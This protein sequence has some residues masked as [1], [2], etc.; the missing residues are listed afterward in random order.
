[1]PLTGQT[2]TQRHYVQFSTCLLICCTPYLHMATSE[3][4]YRP[5]E[6]G[7]LKKLS[8]YYSIV[9]Y[10]NGAQWCEHFLQVRQLYWALILLGLAL[11][12]PSRSVSSVF[13]VLCI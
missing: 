13:M 6:R 3:M 11:F 10:Y 2:G 1:M 4:W 9:Y 12:L 5:A 7:I 8:L